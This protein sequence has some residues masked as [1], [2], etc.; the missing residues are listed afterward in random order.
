MDCTA[1]IDFFTVP[2]LTGRVLYGFVVLGHARRRIIHFN[3]T[4]HPT[5]VWV[6]RQLREAFPFDSA[7]RFLIRDND[8]IFGEEVSRV[9][10]SMNIEEVTTSLGSPW[11]N[12]YTDRFIGTLRRECLDHVIVLNEANLLWVVEE[13]LVY[14]HEARTHQG[15]GRDSPDCRAA[16]GGEG[17]VI[18]EP[19][20]G[21]LHHR[22]RR[23]A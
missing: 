22:Y 10:R 8:A 16:E 11:Q 3:A 6:A 17:L 15:L 18:S 23:A 20:V 2:T 7:P 12:A 14:Y 9:L 21:G 1:A 13:F 19:M 5:S 4:A